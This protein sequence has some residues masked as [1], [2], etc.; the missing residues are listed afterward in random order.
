VPCTWASAWTVPRRS[1]TGCS[2]LDWKTSLQEL[3]AAQGLGAPV[4]AVEDDGPD[5]AKTFTAAVLLAGVVR[6]AGTGRTKKAAEQEAAEAA[7][8]S[9]TAA[10]DGGSAEA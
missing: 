4:Y 7:W 10:A 3:G 8:R 6:G 5:H 2:G 1:C 9:L